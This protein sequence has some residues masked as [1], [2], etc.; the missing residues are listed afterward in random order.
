MTTS[1]PWSFEIFSHRHYW[2]LVLPSLLLWTV[3]ASTPNI[4]VSINGVKKTWLAKRALFGSKEDRFEGRLVHSPDYD[5]LLCEYY[6]K[7]RNY[8][9]EPVED[10]EPWIMMVPRGVCTFERK[11]YAAK[12]WYKADG[13][14]IYDNLSARYQWNNKTEKLRY[15]RDEN[16]YECSK[17]YGFVYNIELDPPR[18]SRNDHDPILDMSR[19]TSNCTLEQTREPCESQLCLVTGPAAANT[20]KYPVCCA[21]DLPMTMGGDDTAGDTDDV[22]AVALTIRQG[23]ELMQFVGETVVVEA[24]P[25]SPWNASMIFL[26]LLG[27]FIT[28][29]SCWFSASDFRI[30]RAQLA[31]YQANKGNQDLVRGEGG[32]DESAWDDERPDPTEDSDLDGL[33]LGIDDINSDDEDEDDEDEGDDDA[34][35][36]RDEDF[37]EG[38]R[39]QEEKKKNRKKK[40]HALHSLPPKGK[41]KEEDRGKVWVLYSLPP[42]ERKPKKAKK[43]QRPGYKAEQTATTDI[44]PEDGGNSVPEPWA[45]PINGFEMTHWHVFGFVI[46]ASVMLFLLFYFQFYSIVFVFYGFGCAGA[47]SHVIFGPVLVRIVPKFG[48]EVVKEL[49]K[50]VC[51]GLNGF[52]IT[53]QLLGYIWA[54][55]WIW[56]VRKLRFLGH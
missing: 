52:D 40:T 6:N 25:Y 48:D 46:M 33:V 32:K 28:F 7:D 18:Y 9:V 56:Y 49:N 19:N 14:L 34:A 54:I 11:A 43:R 23:E 29:I 20:S 13:I 39:E 38:E 31:L 10:H 21:W 41:E 27:V 30:F 16:D 36:T 4:I 3:Q 8:T 51:C 53:S 35:D 55:V 45:T 1:C 15:P 17:G 50:P 37:S 24:R 12:A 42:P 5:E 44:L 26:W 22:V 47:V 2:W